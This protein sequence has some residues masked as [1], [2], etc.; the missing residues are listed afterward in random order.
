[1]EGTKNHMAGAEGV[2]IESL[3]PDLGEV[4]NAVLKFVAWLD[5]FGETSYDYQSYFA[6]R[7]ARSAKAF[8]Y[9]H[10][11][12]GAILVAPMIFSEAFLPS[13]R[14][15]FWKRQRFP[16]ADAHYAMGFAFLSKVLNDERHYLRAVHFL[17]VLEE[18]RCNGCRHYC[19]GYPFSWETRYGTMRTGT[20]LITTVPYAYEAFAQVYEIDG[21][22]KWLEIMRSIA[23]H[24]LKDYHEEATSERAASC[25]Y[26]PEPSCPC[27]VVNASAYRAYLL[28]RAA[29]DLSDPRY[30]R[31]AQ[32]NLNYVLEAQEADGSWRYATDGGRDF[33]D[34]F[35]T[36]FVLK[37]LAKIQAL[38]DNDDCTK[39]IERGVQYYLKNL[40]DDDGDPLPF[41]RRPRFTVYRRELYDY[42]EC[43]N[44]ALLLRRQFPE[45]NNVLRRVID[46]QR[47]QKSDGSFRS[48]QLLV[49]WD[50]TPMHR[51]A[52]SQFFR[53]LCFLLYQET[54]G[55]N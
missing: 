55:K 6:S 42:A 4:R 37:A 14:C 36:C 34:H 15:L 5:K 12:L 21:D 3:S 11:T 29:I 46:L 52:Q 13:A 9:R 51:W 25:S 45:L 7:P 32:G 44:L 8:Y 10:P 28:T 41:A 20:P 50:N 30:A 26:N 53:S 35:H 48:R 24:A 19:W 38:T 33:I 2:A 17:K 31:A 40:F 27:F 43:I 18:T 47:W 49:S 16:I 22:R 39:A 54:C 23:E 1:M